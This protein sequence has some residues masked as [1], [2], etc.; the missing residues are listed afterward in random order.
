VNPD[1]QRIAIAVACG[2]RIVEGTFGFPPRYMIDT[3]LATLPKDVAEDIAAVD[4]CQV[5]YYTTDLNAIAE[6]ERRIVEAGSTYTH[7]VS[8][9]QVLTDKNEWRATAAQRA[10]A[11]LK[12]IGKWEP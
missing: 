4:Y 8:E 9:L 3:Y 7:Y 11:F 10:D 1:K 5:P 6:V 2:W 12:V